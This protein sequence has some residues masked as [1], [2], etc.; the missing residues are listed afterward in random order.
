MFADA[1][2]VTVGCAIIWTEAVAVTEGQPPFAAMVYVTLYVPAVLLEGVIA[3]VEAL[4]V[5]PAVEENVPPIAPDKVT[6]CAD[7]KDL[8]KGDPA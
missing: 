1:G 3:P 2:A 8:Q 7:D 4:I 5:N 6:G